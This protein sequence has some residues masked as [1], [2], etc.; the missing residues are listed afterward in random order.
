MEMLNLR[1]LSEEHPTMPPIT[2]LPITDDLLH[3]PQMELRLMQA[4]DFLPQK[5]QKRT[6]KTSTKNRNTG[7]Q[8]M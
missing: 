8:A 1:L 6:S 4:T 5:H 3:L 2:N 7:G